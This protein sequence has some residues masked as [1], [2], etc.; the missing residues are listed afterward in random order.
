MNKVDS[1]N[2]KEQYEFEKESALRLL[3]SNRAEREILYAEIYNDF[4]NRYPHHR[5]AERSES[6][7]LQYKLL[8]PFIDKSTTF[9][10]IGG[11]NLSLSKEISNVAKKVISIEASEHEDSLLED[12]PNISIH[13]ANMPPYELEGGSIDLAY[14]C[15]FIEHIHPDDALEHAAEINRLL[16]PTGAYI[17]ITPNRVYGPHDV[18]RFFDRKP[19]GLHLKEYIHS[20]LKELFV[21][22]GF[23]EVKLI[24]GIEK[25]PVEIMTPPNILLEKVINR[26]PFAIKRLSL[27]II[28]TLTS[29]QH[30]FRP[31]EQIVLIAYK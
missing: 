12:Y 23:R 31:M 16:S 30:P 25:S 20:D 14:S 19:S 8:K 6:K 15:H 10:E 13:V 17:C 29:T 3:N 11:G 9:L 18:S 7:E 4:Y 1:I 24:P 26:F 5:D 21:K 27:K 2:L 28:S 22:S